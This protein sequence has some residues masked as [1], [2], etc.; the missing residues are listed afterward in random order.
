M[1]TFNVS[2]SVILSSNDSVNGCP[3][4][5]ATMLQE[6]LSNGLNRH[7]RWRAIGRLPLLSVLPAHKHCILKGLSVVS[8][9]QPHAFKTKAFV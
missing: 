7:R 3:Q 8:R 6:V 4:G 5:A 9:A 2:R 1:T